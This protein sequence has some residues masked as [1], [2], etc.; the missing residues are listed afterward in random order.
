MSKALVAVALLM[1]MGSVFGMKIN[2]DPRVVVSFMDKSIPPE[3]DILRVT[4]DISPDNSH[5]VFQ[6]KT[7]GER[8]QGGNNDYL[9]L[10]IMHKKTYI[11]LLPVNTGKEN[12]VLVYERLPQSEDND[13]PPILGKFRGNAYLTNFDITPVS[14]GGEFSVPL[15][16]ID[17]ITSFS[18]DAYTV[19]ARIKGDTLEISKIYDQARKGGVHSN[20]KQS[21]AITLLNKICTPKNNNQRL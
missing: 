19:Q 16:W 1:A 3:L 7:R 8:T 2:P 9:L 13:T 15:D 6:V 10:H 14:R 4:A 5:L 21:S 18:F 12:Q 20:N 17:F 11:L